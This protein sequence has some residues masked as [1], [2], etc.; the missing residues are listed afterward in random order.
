MALVHYIKKKRKLFYGKPNDGFMENQF[1]GNDSVG[2]NEEV[3]LDYSG[4]VREDK[5]H[6]PARDGTLSVKARKMLALSEDERWEIEYEQ[7]LH[8]FYKKC[9]YQYDDTATTLWQL[10]WRTHKIVF[11]KYYEKYKGVG[12]TKV[13][14]SHRRVRLAEHVAAYIYA[15]FFT[16]LYRQPQFNVVNEKLVRTLKLMIKN[17]D[18]FREE[19]GNMLKLI[20]SLKLIL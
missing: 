19:I 5:Q 7:L 14:G 3:E 15:V 1:Y 10:V 18:K 8:F 6:S 13:S 17:E 9:A 20:V 11:P 2:E 12:R 4:G 16:A